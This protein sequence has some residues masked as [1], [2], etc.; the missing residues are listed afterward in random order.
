M[1][2][3]SDPGIINRVAEQA[4]EI[5]T[6][7]VELA[8]SRESER[9]LDEKLKNSETQVTALENKLETTQRELDAITNERLREAKKLDIVG[10]WFTKQTVVD[11]KSRYTP[12]VPLKMFLFRQDGSGVYRYADGKTPPDG[13]EYRITFTSTGT[14][15]VYAIEGKQKNLSGPPKPVGGIFRIQP[16]GKSAVVEGWDTTDQPADFVK[17]GRKTDE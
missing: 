6:L 11:P 9:S 13:I 7:K 2:G 15:G 16:D 14:A 17:A 3:C 1:S 10:E 12:I 5:A 4:S 8:T